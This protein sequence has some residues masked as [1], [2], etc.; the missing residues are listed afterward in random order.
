MKR[1]LADGFCVRKVNYMPAD[2]PTRKL[3]FAAEFRDG[4]EKL[5]QEHPMRA[6]DADLELTRTLRERGFKLDGKN[7]RAIQAPYVMNPSAVRELTR[8]VRLISK[9][10][11][12]VIDLAINSVTLMEQLGVSPNIEELALH[13]A[14]TRLAIEFAR[15]DFIP[16]GGGPV[17]LEFNVDSPAG[18][19]F[20]NLLDSSFQQIPLAR[21]SGFHKIFPSAPPIELYVDAVMAAYREHTRAVVDRPHVAVVDFAGAATIPEQ[22]LVVQ[23]LKSRGLTAALVDP[24]EFQFNKSDRGLYHDGTR[25]HLVVRRALVPELGRRRVLVQQF[26]RGI[27]YGEVVTVNPIRS[28]LAGDKGL[29]EM[30]TSSAFD[31]FFTAT[32]NQAKARLLPWTRK[33]F[34]RNTDYHGRQIDLVQFI[35]KRPEK[36]VLKPGSG[37]G[38]QD[39]IL[40]PFC[41]IQDWQARLEEFLNQGGVVQEYV[42][43]K[44][45]PTPLTEGTSVVTQ[46]GYLTLG[47]FAIRGEYAGCIGRVSQDPVVNVARGG[48]IVPVF[49]VGGR[50]KTGP[51]AAARPR[52][53]RT[54]SNLR[55]LQ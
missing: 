43:V 26:L 25:Y 1:Q 38:G 33:L 28:R 31:R 34:E 4:F 35:A 5:L 29:M 50:S 47:A 53:K 54:S 42:P 7:L 37:F 49:E 3:D 8:S 17:F 23:E 15:Y 11:E 52:R 41:D 40:G 20:S 13:D 51:I 9:L 36:F 27:R 45:H 2:R 19:G 39:V 44:K 46:E 18:A 24:R 6:R 48:G 21:E 32:E 30:L 16:T 12:Q 10:L 14:P 55:H 22:E